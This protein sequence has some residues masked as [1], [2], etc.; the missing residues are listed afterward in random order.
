MSADKTPPEPPNLTALYWP[1]AEQSELV[2][3]NDTD[4]P[5]GNPD[6]RWFQPNNS[7]MRARTWPEAV[8]LLAVLGCP[9][10]KAIRLK[11]TSRARRETTDG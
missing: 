7:S 6:R 9:I 8:E 11:A 2:I 5:P 10:N 1:A 4:A 3:R